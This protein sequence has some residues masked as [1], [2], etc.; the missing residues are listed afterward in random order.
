MKA[1][2]QLIDNY[3]AYT[4]LWHRATGTAGIVI[5]WVI[6]CDNAVSLRVDYGP[7]GCHVKLPGVMSATKPAED[8]DEW[9][10]PEEGSNGSE[11]SSSH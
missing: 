6:D 8:G 9:K 5:G 3:P 4:K 1:L 10:N 2:Q 11:S 7:N